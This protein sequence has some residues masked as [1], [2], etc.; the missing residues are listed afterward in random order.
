MVSDPDFRFTLP[1]FT[2]VVGAGNPANGSGIGVMP[3]T[4]VGLTVAPFEMLVP[5]TTRLA[6][7]VRTAFPEAVSAV[8]E[9]ESTTT[10]PP[11]FA[12]TVP[13]NVNAPFAV[14]SRTKMD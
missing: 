10:T 7:E 3:V 14:G 6:L 2:P 1:R 5:P 9:L 13:V 12:L 4:G 8:G 11:K